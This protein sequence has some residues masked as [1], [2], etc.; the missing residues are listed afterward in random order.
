VKIENLT[1]VEIADVFSIKRQSGQLKVVLKINGKI[2]DAD[3]EKVE[4]GENKQLQ[5]KLL[6]LKSEKA[7]GNQ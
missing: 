4:I 2:W 3:V 1:F 5:V 7:L 6:K